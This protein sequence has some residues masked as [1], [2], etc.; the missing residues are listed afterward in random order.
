MGKQI[1]ISSD[2][3]EITTRRQKKN[4]T[5]QFFHTPTGAHY[6]SYANG[7]V[8]REIRMNYTYECFDKLRGVTISPTFSRRLQYQL[9][10]I[11][12]QGKRTR[13]VMIPNEKDRIERINRRAEIYPGYGN[14][15]FWG[16]HINKEVSFY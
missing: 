4:G 10:P 13:R 7:Y 3:Q 15:S 2:L 11:I 8:R 16:G 6:I 12:K 14:Y 9:N 1:E 5:R